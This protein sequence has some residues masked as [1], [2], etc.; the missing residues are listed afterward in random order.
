MQMSQNKSIQLKAGAMLSYLQAATG[1]IIS[2]IYTP[3][4]LSLLGQSE[5]GVYNIAAITISYVNLLNMGFSSSYVRFYSRDKA[6]G[7]GEKLART[8]GLFLLVFI[9][10]GLLALFAGIVL[11]GFS[12]L[13]FADGLTPAEYV[14]IKKI[15]MI[16]TVSTAY[17][18]ATSIFPSIVIAHERFIF[19]RVVNLIKTVLSPSITWIL[20]LAGYRSVMMAFVTAVLTVVADTFYLIYCFVKLKIKINMRNPS[21]AQ[22]KEIAMFSGFITLTSVVDQINWGIDKILLGRMKGTAETSVYSIAAAIQ[23]MFLQLSSSISNVFIPRVNRLVAENRPSREITDIFIRIGRIQAS[24]LL[25]IFLGF[26]F[27]GKS[28]ISLWIPDGY[29]KVYVIA[30]LLMGSSLVPFIQN[31]GISIQMA[32]NRHQFRAVIYTVIAIINLVLSIFLCKRYGAIG[33]AAGTACSLLVGNVL[34]MNVYYHKAIK[35]DMIAFWKNILRFLPTI[36]VL[37]ICGLAITRFVRIDNWMM[38]AISGCLFVAVYVAMLWFT[39][40]TKKERKEILSVIK[41]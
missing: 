8:N 38:F 20:L 29:S 14:C 17:N 23:T 2:L 12:E 35:I 30:V 27:L 32:Q 16:L 9:V 19:H 41:R 33:C 39:V 28:F 21:G 40:L 25:P 36:A 13:I 18:L 37:I 11:T 10:I 24:V 4:M 6:E 22:L 15:M 3:V 1:A 31:I 26:V 7:C 5:Y 34:I